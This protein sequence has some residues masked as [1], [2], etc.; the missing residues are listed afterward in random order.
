[1]SKREE[2][3]SAAASLFAVKGF[4]DTTMGEVAAL[5][6][7]AASTVFYHFKTKEEIFLS[8]LQSVEE[9]IRQ[10]VH[11]HRQQLNS[12]PAK[13]IDHVLA[14][15]D[16][17]LRLAGSRAEIFLIL[18][19]RF[20]YELAVVNDA[21]RRRLEQIH[22]LFTLLFED[23]VHL[24]HADG[25][26]VAGDPRRIAMVVFALVDGLIKV[27]TFHLYEA[28]ALYN[29]ALALTRRMLQEETPPP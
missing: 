4:R 9:E 10:A 22:D 28:A 3:L 24:G 19:H 8:I 12:R 27:K 14:A 6:G 25:S 29:E 7:T 17:M 5:V 1:M 26:V 2:I 11:E 23:A 18:H 21:C 16:F 20:P 15:V 13:G